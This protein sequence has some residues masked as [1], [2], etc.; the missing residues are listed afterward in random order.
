M[1]EARKCFLF[2][3]FKPWGKQNNLDFD[4]KVGVW[5]GA[6]CCELVGLYMLD[7]LKELGLNPIQ[8][9]GKN[10]FVKF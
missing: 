1:F 5:D 2:N 10:A 8:G 3:E 6:E 9:G 7:R 4:V